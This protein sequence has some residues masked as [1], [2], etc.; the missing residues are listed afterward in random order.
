MDRFRSLIL[1]LGLVKVGDYLW[2]APFSR[3]TKEA[4]LRDLLQES[5]EL[6][7]ATSRAPKAPLERCLLRVLDVLRGKTLIPVLRP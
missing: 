4:I 1:R 3:N 6:V 7:L 2:P 5:A